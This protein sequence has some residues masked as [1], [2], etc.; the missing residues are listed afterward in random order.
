[1]LDLKMQN[2]PDVRRELKGFE[3]Q[4]PFAM[5]L[6]LTRTAK[7]VEVDLRQTMER[8]FNNPKPFTV[9]STYT[10]PARKQQLQAVVGLKDSISKGTSAAQYLQ[11]Q[12]GGGK[13]E[14]KR[15]ERSSSF[16][17]RLKRGQYLVPGRDANLNKF[18]NLTLAVIKKV[19]ED[20]KTQDLAASLTSRGNNRYFWMGDKGVFYRQGKKLRSLLVTV[21]G[22]TYRRKFDFQRSTEEAVKRNYGPEMQRAIRE[23]LDSARG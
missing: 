13:R 23:A 19:S 11:P 10:T 18:G 5:A 8:V 21:D 9:K 3:K 17:K 16:K 7:A 1:M 15:F 20:L 22:A 2:L 12:I 14:P 6:G 4:I